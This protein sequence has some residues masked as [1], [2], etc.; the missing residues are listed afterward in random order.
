MWLYG[1][2]LITGVF[3][4]ANPQ[5]GFH[6][7]KVVKSNTDIYVALDISNS[8]KAEDLA[9]DRLTRAK[10]YATNLISRLKGNN[11]G[12]IFFAG[13]AYLQMP[14]TSDH[15]AAIMM[16][17]A[18][19]MELAGLQGTDI[20][21]VAS[22][23]K[24]ANQTQ[25]RPSH[26]L[27]MITD[28]ED[29]EQQGVDAIADLS[30]TGIKTFVIAAGT[31]QGGYINMGSDYKRDP[32]TG[33]PILTKINL[34]YINELAKA[35]NG[36][37]FSMED[38]SS[39]SKIESEIQVRSSKETTS[40]TINQYNSFFQYF[41]LI[42][43]IAFLVELL[44]SKYNY[45]KKGRSTL[46]ILIFFSVSFLFANTNIYAQKKELKQGVQSY[47]KQDFISAE[48]KFSKAKSNDRSGKS[49]YNLGN[50][51]YKQEK[52]EDAIKAYDEVENNNPSLK[53]KSKFNSGNAKVKI[54]KY[55]EG[56]KDYKDALKN[57]SLDKDALNNLLKAKMDLH[58]K[59]QQD[60]ENQ[61]NKD[62][63]KN[64]QQNQKQNK[65][66]QDQNK[67]QKDDPKNQNNQDKKN[68]QNSQNQNKDQ[69]PSTPKDLSKNQALQ[70][71]DREEEKVQKKL[72]RGSSK[73]ETPQK[74]W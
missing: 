37:A 22:L 44:L 33:S 25:N 46:S 29:H 51:L 28:G 47:E 72:K 17:N 56:I 70:M 11:I 66:Q 7:E 6:N 57:Q 40:K 19:D 58:K 54:Q 10:Q 60:K 16:V 45:M 50:S 14:L 3:A 38:E 21:S 52:Y 2:G 5:Y 32:A 36:K 30:E 67:E 39:I 35:G 27:V 49:A 1:L 69:N 15:A 42:T 41:A 4:L 12:L 64:N 31:E 26:Y 62:N 65:D 59:K 34:P 61:S 18:A 9:P 63:Q 24:R 23:I 55:D 48:Q 73:S 53:Q 20:A 13:E 71:I 68:Q 8:M 43:L 74:D